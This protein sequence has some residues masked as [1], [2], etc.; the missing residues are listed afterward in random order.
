[1]RPGVG[2]RRMGKKSPLFSLS[3]IVISPAKRK[4]FSS[5]EAINVS[6][7]LCWLQNN[8]PI[9]PSSKNHHQVLPARCNISPI[10]ESPFM[11]IALLFSGIFQGMSLAA[12]TVSHRSPS[13]TQSLI[14]LR[15]PSYFFISQGSSDCVATTN[16]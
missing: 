15:K 10:P 14:F 12:S 13:L 16:L 1:M 7:I 5:E 6:Q 3:A 9:N 8:S 4:S 2:Q 11:K